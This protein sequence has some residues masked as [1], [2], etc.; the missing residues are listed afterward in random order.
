MTVRTPGSTTSDAAV[1]ALA[2]SP[3]PALVPD[4][5]AG[6]PAAAGLRH[7]LAHL[8]AWVGARPLVAIGVAV[9]VTRLAMLA[10]MLRAE[11]GSIRASI[12]VAGR[13]SDAGWYQAIVADGYAGGT[14]GLRKAAFY[15]GYP[16]L[17]AALYE[18]VKAVQH[19]AHLPEPAAWGSF[20]S[21]PLVV[22]A[23]LVVSNACLVVALVA[24]W[25]LY[26]PR[27]GT[28]ATLLGSC[29]L[30][31]APNAFFLSSGH[32]ESAFLAA[33]VLAFLFAERGR[34]VAA[35]LAA[36]AA[37]L[38]RSP[39]VL[40]L[41]PLAIIWLRSSRPRGPALAGLALALA[42]VVAFPAYTGFAFA[43]PLLYEHVETAWHPQRANPIATYVELLHRMWWGVREELGIKPSPLTP[44][45]SAKVQALDG[46][47]LLWASACTLLG[48]A[49][50]GLAHVAWIFLAVV[51]PLPA[52]GS[53]ISTNRYLLVAFPAFFLTGWWLRRRPLLALPLVVVGLVG[54]FVLSG[55]ATS[56][57]VG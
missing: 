12:E 32:S 28:A 44:L 8:G 27:L 39:G 22:L 9:V 31:A 50:L 10:G 26:Q 2:P 4:D 37:A 40:L 14:L 11:H 15:P 42:G 36:G 51:F 30:V 41:L 35:G 7:G 52:G 1:E 47:M 43:D 21:D 29:L 46:L 49:P 53:P 33:T 17:V 13:I 24:L 20:G 54:L 5:A 16:M 45:Y 38:I 18:P 19:A 6:R 34:W 56:H 25:H 23:Q 48:R 3:L 55:E 57:F